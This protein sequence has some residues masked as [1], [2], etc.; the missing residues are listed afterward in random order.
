[1]D[2]NHLI[3]KFNLIFLNVF[4]LI[5]IILNVN[6]MASIY[7][8]L[9]F[10]VSSICHQSTLLFVMVNHERLIVYFKNFLIFQIIPGCCYRVFGEDMSSFSKTIAI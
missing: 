2:V 3:R 9:F 5:I 8:S 1:M 10:R 6:I 4:I 7:S